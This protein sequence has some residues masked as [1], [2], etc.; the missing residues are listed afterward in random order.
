MFF[1]AQGSVETQRELNSEECVAF[2]VCSF[3]VQGLNMPSFTDTEVEMLIDYYHDN[4]DLWDVT[5]EGH[6][7]QQI[8]T[9]KLTTFLE[10][11]LDPARKFLPF[12]DVFWTPKV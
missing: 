2:C 12:R 1:T 7:D 4:K 10:K 5:H 8:R 11:Y 3:V 9:S 6:K